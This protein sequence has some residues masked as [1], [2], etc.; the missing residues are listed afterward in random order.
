MK[1]PPRRLP[2]T[3]LS[4]RSRAKRLA[5]A[6]FCYYPRVQA[7]FR[8]WSSYTRLNPFAVL[9]NHLVCRALFLGAIAPANCRFSNFTSI[10]C[11]FVYHTEQT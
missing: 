1:T 5:N 4:S 7:V 9:L 3:R 11:R 6:D 8:L 2:H 10:I